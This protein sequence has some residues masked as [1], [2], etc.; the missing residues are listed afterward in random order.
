[1]LNA[2]SETTFDVFNRNIV[3]AF[4]HSLA[5]AS[6][7]DLIGVQEP[8]YANARKKFFREGCLPRAVAAGDEIDRG[9]GIAQKS[10]FVSASSRNQQ[11]GSLRSPDHYVFA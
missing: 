11:A 10:K 8:N 1:M 5:H 9:E 4:D 6:N 7:R 3:A 2:S